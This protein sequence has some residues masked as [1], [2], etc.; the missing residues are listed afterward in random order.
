LKIWRL[1][2]AYPHTAKERPLAKELHPNH[3]LPKK[4]KYS[5]IR[6]SNLLV[7]VVDIL[8][9]LKTRLFILPSTG[10]TKAFEHS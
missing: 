10:D 1:N 8:F 4:G 6:T 5:L 2:E 3:D 9:P 7:H